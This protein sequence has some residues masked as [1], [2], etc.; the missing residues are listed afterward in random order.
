MQFIAY[1][2]SHHFHTPILKKNCPKVISS[3]LTRSGQ[4]TLPPKTFVMLKRLNSYSFW[5]INM[6]RS[7]YHETIGSYKTYILDFWFWWPKARSILWPPHSK[8]M[9][10]KKSAF[11]YQVWPFNHELSNIRLLLMIKVQI[12]VGDF[13]KSHWGHMTSS[14]VT[15]RFLL[16]SHDWKELQTSA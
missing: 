7:G 9:G 12:L 14:E 3:Q 5:A 16:I 13:H 10:E 15:N 1:L 2:I 6:K 11:T 8:A 4:V